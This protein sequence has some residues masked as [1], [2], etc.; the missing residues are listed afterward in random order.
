MPSGEEGNKAHH[1]SLV[2]GLETIKGT[3]LATRQAGQNLVGVIY[4]T[5]RGG[6][7]DQKTIHAAQR[8]LLPGA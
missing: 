3:T 8:R 2:K 7:D 5:M 6:G 1:C 4:A